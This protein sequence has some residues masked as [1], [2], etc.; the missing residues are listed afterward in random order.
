MAFEQARYIKLGSGASKIDKSCINR[1]IAYIGF[2]TDNDQLFKAASSGDWDA[3]KRLT[4]ER[5]T[6]GS[7]QARKRNTTSAANQVKT[8]FEA[9]DK[10]LWITFCEGKLF[11]G[12]LSSHSKPVIDF[13]LR[14]CVRHL[15][16]GWSSTDDRGV[17]L[18]VENL[19]GNL[20]KVRRFQGTSCALGADQLEY[21]LR[22]LSGRVPEFI[23]RIDHAREMM[24]DAVLSAIRTLQPKDFELLVENIFSGSW[25]RIGQMGGS[26]KYIDIIY[27]EPLNPDRRIALQVKSE[28]SPGEVS[29]YCQDEQ[30]NAYE[31]LFFVF[32]TPTQDDILKD[33]EAP[34]GLELID[35]KK[36]ASLVVD[37]GLIHW[38]REKT[39]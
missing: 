14:G 19:S 36:L 12:V 39:S 8:F 5:D 10:T 9:D 29:R 22:R 4:N 11:H 33:Y 21:L 23:D 13:N 28:T 16:S 37:S 20:T 35:G 31:K 30:F 38:L 25:R 6:S 27:E 26:E 18:R 2:G 7:E 34:E 15:E 32:H 1:G 24:E 3:F 17:P